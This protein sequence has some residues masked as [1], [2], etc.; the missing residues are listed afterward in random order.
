M[1]DRGQPAPAVAPVKPQENSSDKF[2]KAQNPDLYY[3][4]SYMECYYFCQQCKDDFETTKAKSHKRIPFAEI[5]LKNYIFNCWQQHK[6]QT[7][8]TQAN[9]LS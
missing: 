7:E 2:F 9:P 8:H 4:N 1:E 3:G 5:F 6:A